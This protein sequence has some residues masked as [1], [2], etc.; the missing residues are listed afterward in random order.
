MAIGS[1]VLNLSE[2]TSGAGPSDAFYAFPC[3][4]PLLRL[5]GNQNFHPWLAENFTIASD[6]SSITLYLRHNVKF[7][8]GTDFN[9][10]A[11]VYAVDCALAN[12]QYTI[13]KAFKEPVVIDPYTVKLNFIDGKWN[14][15]SAKGLAYW[16]GL[17]MYSPTAAKVNG[18][19]WLKTHIVGTGPFILTEYKLNQKA[20]YD[21]NPNYW[22]GA[23]YLD[24]MDFN[25]IPDVTTQLLAYKAGEI[26]VLGAQL[27]DV[28]TLE[29]QGFSM[30]ESDDAVTNF[31]LVPS[32][33]NPDS[34][35]SD[36]RVRQA[37][38]YAIDQDAM[39]TGLTY[40][41]GK[42]TQ[43]LFP[44][45]AYMNS[46]VVGYPFSIQ[47]AKDLL[48]QAGYATGLTLTL[49]YNEYTNPDVPPA[50]KDMFAKVGITLVLNKVSYLQSA[51]M[52]FTSG[53]DGFLLSYTF[54]GNTV[55]PGFS[56][57][58]Y[59]T[60]GGWVSLAKPADIAAE[61]NAAVERNMLEIE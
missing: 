47:K 45:G 24:G 32:S 52:I 25:I 49:T 18:K 60:Q 29:A 14:W 56:A 41:L 12:P 57:G 51:A 37:V 2:I 7:S 59:I 53:W 28:A 36:V 1:A 43:Q 20:V 11:V 42:T 19:D 38:Q 10:D 5:D 22:R 46:D 54:P 13:G 39:I 35:L 40:G 61:I 48:A 44:F 3:V 33:N 55:D 17:L 4:E 34:A 15:D 50:L 16:W 8:D 26:H 31:C 9:A 23:P 21:K 27:K 6:F 58:M 30:T